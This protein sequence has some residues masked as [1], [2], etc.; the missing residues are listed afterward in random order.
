MCEEGRR[1]SFRIRNAHVSWHAIFAKGVWKSHVDQVPLL[2]TAHV[3][4]PYPALETPGY[5]QL[6]LRDMGLPPLAEPPTDRVAP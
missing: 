1:C 6:S 3:W 5:C 4:D 2:G